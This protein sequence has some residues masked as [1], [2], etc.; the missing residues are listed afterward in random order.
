MP[1]VAVVQGSVFNLFNNGGPGA[2]CGGSAAQCIY[3]V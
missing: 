1:C 2:V 3:G